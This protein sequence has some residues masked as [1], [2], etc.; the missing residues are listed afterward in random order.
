MNEKGQILAKIKFKAIIDPKMYKGTLR[1]F[2]PEDIQMTKYKCNQC[3]E[4]DSD[5]TTSSPTVLHCW[6]CKSGMRMSIQ[7]QFD[8][9]EGMFIVVDGKFPWEI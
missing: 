2:L 4:E 7:E 8:K 1:G 3:G 6:S 5:R 9:R